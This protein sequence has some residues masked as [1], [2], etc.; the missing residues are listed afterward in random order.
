[1]FARLAAMDS[2]ALTAGETLLMATR[3]GA[4]ALGRPDIG[5]LEPGRWADSL[6]GLVH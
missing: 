2:L 6:P 4:E 3:G 5:A 1:M